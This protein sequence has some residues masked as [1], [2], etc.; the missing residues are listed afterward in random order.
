MLEAK[1][2]S[3]ALGLVPLPLWKPTVAVIFLFG[4]TPGKRPTLGSN[5][6][7]T[8]RGLMN[9]SH[10]IL[11]SVVPQ[12]LHFPCSAFLPFFKTTV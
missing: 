2:S 5:P 4:C 12:E 10:F 3:R 9:T 7:N 1:T 11:K 8:E 6:F